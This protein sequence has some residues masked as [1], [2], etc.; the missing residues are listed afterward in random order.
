MTIMSADCAKRCNIMR[1]VDKRFS[2][3][4]K[5]VGTQPIL[6]KVHLAQIQIENIF[7]PVSFSVMPDQPMDVL[8]GLDML[9]RLAT[10]ILFLN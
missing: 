8:L 3:I 5:G 2:G 9:R 6:G 4:A 1:L 10:Y 7:L